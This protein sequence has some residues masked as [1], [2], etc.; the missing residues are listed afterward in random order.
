MIHGELDDGVLRAGDGIPTGQLADA[1][2]GALAEAIGPLRPS[3]HTRECGRA[4]TTCQYDVPHQGL[5][6]RFRGFVLPLSGRFLCR[7]APPG[8]DL[9]PLEVDPIGPRG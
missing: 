2:L 3:L 8:P 5:S 4:K 9:V 7:P 6:I 1:R